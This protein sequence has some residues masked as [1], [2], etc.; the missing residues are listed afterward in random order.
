MERSARRLAWSA[1]IVGW[2][3]CFAGLS[4]AADPLDPRAAPRA[5]LE[6]LLACHEAEKTAA[7]HERDKIASH[8]REVVTFRSELTDAPQHRLA[9]E[10]AEQALAKDREAMVKA[11]ERLR[12]ADIQVRMT[13]QAMR[14]LPPPVTDTTPGTVEQGKRRLADLL[15]R[16]HSDNSAATDQQMEREHGFIEDPGLHARLGAILDRLKAVSTEENVPAAVRILDKPTGRD[17]FATGTTIYFDKQY[18]DRLESRYKAPKA[19]E[20]QLMVTM[21]HEL[22]HLQLHH[23]NLGFAQDK[24]QRLQNAVW[25][26]DVEGTHDDYADPKKP[27]DDAAFRAQLAEYQRDQEYQ[28]DLL[29]SQQALAAGVSPRS[30]KESFTRMWFDDLKQRLALSSNGVEPRY[31]KMLEDHA[32]PDE[33]LKALETALGEKFWEQDTVRFSASCR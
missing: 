12:L 24:W 1:M 31:A 2:L 14:Y 32:R 21:G 25:L 4:L 16:F 8:L 22:A 10:K 6:R 33:R 29:G 23:V 28:A 15:A 3:L 7:L 18:L 26:R 30:I 5:T 17:A 27:T 13:L 20:D 9:V 11:E 19:M